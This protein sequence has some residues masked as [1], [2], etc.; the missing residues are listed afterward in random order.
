MTSELR[1]EIKQAVKEALIELLTGNDVS[2]AEAS[3]ILKVSERTVH[4]WVKNGKIN[5]NKKGKINREELVRVNG[6]L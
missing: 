1:Y 5:E 6:Q 2:K 4:R 3:R